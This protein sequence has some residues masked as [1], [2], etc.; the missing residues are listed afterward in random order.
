MPS[1][2]CFSW[3]RRMHA[4]VR[5]MCVFVCCELS[6]R[7]LPFVVDWLLGHRTQRTRTSTLHWLACSRSWWSCSLE[8]LPV[9]RRRLLC[10]LASVLPLTHRLPSIATVWSWYLIYLLLSICPSVCLSKLIWLSPKTP[11]S[12]KLPRT[13]KFRGSRR[14]GI[15][16]KGDVTGLSRTCRGRHGEVHLLKKYRSFVASGTAYDQNFYNAAVPCL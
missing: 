6:L 4:N 2:C 7:A 14:N 10:I 8:V 13:G 12:P 11:T 15:C 5:V 16:A 1:W 9:N 3:R